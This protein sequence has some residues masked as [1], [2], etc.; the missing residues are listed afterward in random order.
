M[1]APITIADRAPPSRLWPTI[2]PPHANC[3]W[4]CHHAGVRSCRDW[5][6]TYD[7]GAIGDCRYPTTPLPE[8]VGSPS[9]QPEVHAVNRCG[10][11]RLLPR[12]RGGGGR[13][14]RT[15]AITSSTV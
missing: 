12:S 6:P 9:P 11:G 5:L 4:H 15:S 14:G 8:P 1:R 3:G 2:T 7:K 13:A 10:V